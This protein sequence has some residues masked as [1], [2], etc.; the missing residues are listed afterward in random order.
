MYLESRILTIDRPYSRKL[1]PSWRDIG[2][3]KID[4]EERTWK[5][6]LNRAIL[7]L[8]KGEELDP[9]LDLRTE[10]LSRKRRKYSWENRAEMRG[11]EIR[12]LNFFISILLSVDFTFWNTERQDG[13]K[14]NN[15]NCKPPIK[16]PRI[17]FW[18]DLL[19]NKIELISENDLESNAAAKSVEHDKGHRHDPKSNTDNFADSVLVARDVLLFCGFG[20]K[21]KSANGKQQDKDLHDK[22]DPPAAC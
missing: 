4:L 3:R 6:K 1:A 19:K 10:L 15:S 14:S 11:V 8:L 17:S 5:R 9:L 21:M 2:K 7:E 13:C 22:T 20:Q 16:V 12:F 18:K